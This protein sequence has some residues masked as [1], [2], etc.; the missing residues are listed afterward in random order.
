ML[1]RHD[2]ISFKCSVNFINI[3]LQSKKLFRYYIERKLNN[4]IYKVNLYIYIY[5]IYRLFCF[6]LQIN[7][8]GNNKKK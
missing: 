8:K 1:H 3:K 2:F 4:N 5:L 7:D 6:I